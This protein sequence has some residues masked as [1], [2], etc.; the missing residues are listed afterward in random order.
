MVRFGNMEGF[1]LQE[2]FE[3]QVEGLEYYMLLNKIKKNK[4]NYIFNI[5]CK[6]GL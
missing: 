6:Q 3:T 4:R 5:Y 2:D 1:K